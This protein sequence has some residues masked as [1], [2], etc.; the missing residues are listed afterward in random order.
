MDLTALT[1]YGVVNLVMV[2]SH[3]VVPG[4]I[5]QFPFWAGMLALGWFFPQAVGGYLNIDSFPANAYADGLFFAALCTLCLWVGFE[6]A[7]RRSPNLKASWLDAPFDLDRLYFAGAML[8]LIGFFFQWKLQALPEELLSE[9]QPS[10]LVVKYMFLGSIF[11]F[12][13]LTLWLLYLSQPRILIPKLLVLIIPSLGLI[14]EAAV[15]G[16]RRA[17]MMDVVSYIA[18]SLWFT[19]RISI[20]RGFILL[21][22]SLGLVLVNGIRTYR[23]ILMDKEASLSERITEA[24]N[25]DYLSTS[26]AQLEDSGAEF[27]NYIFYRQIHAK[28]GIYDYGI[29][30]WNRFV[31][32]YVPG[33]LV[34]RDLKKKLKLKPTD[35]DI[36]DHVEEEYGHKFK[37]GTTSTGYKDSFGSFGWFGGVKFLIIGLLMGT[38]Y[39]HA[40]QGAF[41]GQLLYVYLL[42]KGMQCVSHGTNGILVRA[43]IYFFVLGYP[44]FIWAKKRIPSR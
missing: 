14:F 23:L 15:L 16:G 34:G 17:A 3:L 6:H 5:Y 40:M 44:F 18:V 24:V 4:K 32:N 25:A 43:W 28:L 31:Y 1:L 13:F 20:P 22:L 41:L 10:G 35:L 29:V 27:K 33:Q 42:A 2:I 11:K 39:R 21:G 12:G 36:K 37:L 38:L 8:C 30:H 9:T 19:R 26:Q 7:V